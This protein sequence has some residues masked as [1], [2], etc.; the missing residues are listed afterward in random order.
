MEET[1]SEGEKQVVEILIVDKET[2]ELSVVT[3]GIILAFS[4]RG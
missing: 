1:H 4:G 2:H 3:R